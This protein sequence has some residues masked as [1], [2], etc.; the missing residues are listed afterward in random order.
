MDPSSQAYPALVAQ[1]EGFLL[2]NLG[3][4]GAQA[5]DIMPLEV[6]P[7]HA[8]ITT[9]PALTTLLVGT[10]NIDPTLS[11]GTKEDFNTCQLATLS[12]LGLPDFYKVRSNA[13]GVVSTGAS[14][15]DP[16][17]GYNALFTDLP[18]AS[19]SFPVTLTQAG[20]VYLWYRILNNSTGVF[21][22]AVDSQ[23]LGS[24][25]NTLSI[26]IGRRASDSIAFFRI[27]SVAEGAHI[28]TLTQASAS[29]SAVGI[30][31]VGTPPPH[32]PSNL[33]LVLVGTIPK[34]LF[35][36]GGGPC[37][38]LPASDAACLAYTGYIEANVDLL[39]NDGLNL[40]LF[41]TRKYMAG[42]LVDMTDGLHPNA[43][44][45]Q[46]IA[47]SLLDALQ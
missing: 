5:C 40:K 12:W 24:L 29:G 21:T 3:Y 14:H 42:T 20:A 19:V 43:L 4:G 7:S 8:E 27:P 30:V 38:F 44:G 31:A 33:P 22:Y 17:N 1:S 34:Q 32:H 2:T 15:L 18:G 46:E 13:T 28:I 36:S 25:E 26:P 11:P 39:T 16:T 6:F 41:D 45:Q 23:V 35:Y 37:A 9:L 10:N 47:H